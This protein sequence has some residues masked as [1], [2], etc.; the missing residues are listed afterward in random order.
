MGIVEFIGNE[1]L[2]Q[3]EK[4]KKK[5]FEELLRSIKPVDDLSDY[6]RLCW[7]SARDYKRSSGIEDRIKACK[8]MREGEYDPDRAAEIERIGGSKIFMMLTDEKC[9]AAESWLLDIL[10]GKFE[11]VWDITTT[12]VVDLPP[13]TKIEI[14]RELFQRLSDMLQQGL[15]TQEDLQK[16]SDEIY[17]RLKK[18][19][20]FKAK[21][22][23]QKIK[24]YLKDFIEESGFIDALQEAIIDGIQFPAGIMKFPV[25]RKRK[26]LAYMKDGSVGVEE[27]IVVE[28]E[29][30]SP[31]DLYPSKNA[32]NVNDGFII[33]HHRLTRGDLLSLRGVEGY[34]D[35]EIDA[36]LEEVDNGEF[37]DWLW[38]AVVETEVSESN[39]G[40]ISYD[41]VD[42]KIDALQFWGSVNGRK[43]KKY[44]I[45]NIDENKEYEVEVWLIDRH[46]IRCVLNANPLGRKPYHLFKFRNLPGEFWGMGLPELMKDCQDACNAAARNLVNN[47]AIASGPQVA[48]DV[49]ALPVGED[50]TSLY[51]W[52]IW[53]FS[54]DIGQSIHFFA[55]PSMIT[56]L[57]KVYEFFSNEADNKT[58]IPKYSYGVGAGTGALSTATGFTMMMNNA[59]RGIK[60]VV[61]NVDKLI[62]SAIRS[63]YEWVMLYNPIP[64]FRGDLKIVVKGSKALLEKEYLHMR[65]NEFMQIV[66]SRPEILSI[67]GAEGLAS[68]LRA[69]AEGLQFDIEEIVPDKMEF[70]ARMRAMQMKQMEGMMSQANGQTSPNLPRQPEPDNAGN[71]AGGRDVNVVR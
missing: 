46:V 61:K 16:D 54:K 12:E 58:G 22:E 45:P 2:E 59:T 69:V 36:V 42:K 26:Q 35:K 71:V 65:R 67:I 70:E 41:D 17:E 8:R 51:P 63:L 37:S 9:N 53:Q 27:K 33:E 52:K 20:S 21:E 39:D 38:D 15:I 1:E 24:N 10:A 7:Q 19:M 49:N 3:M 6:V 57:L 43:L 56:E 62:E 64:E 48:I 50:I 31:F 5:G 18:D 29:R 25:V 28:A 14:M 13:S 40:F 47:M 11:D 30:V 60:R 44:N 55:P 68:M 34:I 32:T 23:L 4:E 66:F